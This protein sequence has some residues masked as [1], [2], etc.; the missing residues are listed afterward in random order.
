VSYVRQEVRFRPEAGMPVDI[1]LRLAGARTFTTKVERVGPQIELVPEH[2]RRDPR[3]L[4]WGLPVRIA[5]PPD[6]TIRP[7]ELVDVYY[8]ANLL[9]KSTANAPPQ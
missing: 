8:R 7:G 4:E 5:V 3:L 1:R 9:A 6:L 2:Q